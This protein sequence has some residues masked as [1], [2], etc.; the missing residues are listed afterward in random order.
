[1]SIRAVM[2]EQLSVARHIVSD[3]HE[4][5]PAWRIKSPPSVLS[6]RYTRA[7]HGFGRGMG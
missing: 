5:V 2:L 7:R 1:M 6:E 3:G 4:V